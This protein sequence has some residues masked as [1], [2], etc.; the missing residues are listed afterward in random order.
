MIPEK[1]CPNKLTGTVIRALCKKI[2][3]HPDTY[4]AT[5]PAITLYVYYRMDYYR[6]RIRKGTNSF[7]AF[8][9]HRSSVKLLISANGM[10]PCR[11]AWL[12]VIRGRK[13]P[14]HPSLF[15]QNRV[16]RK[17]CLC[18]FNECQPRMLTSVPALTRS[19]NSSR[20][21]LRIRMQ[22]MD[23]GLPISTL[24]GLPWI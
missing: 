8:W 7:S 22:P 9:N 17:S 21:L 6:M 24:S 14:S 1:A 18:F 2:I 5:H 23:P 13:Q 4:P 12:S 16:K 19:N 15:L 10:N 20:S 3:A 11:G